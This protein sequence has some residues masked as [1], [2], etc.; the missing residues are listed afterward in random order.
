MEEKLGT[1]ALL[2][3][4]KNGTVDLIVALT[5]GLV[6]GMGHFFEIKTFAPQCL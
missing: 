5:E 2:N 3:L 1:G 4:L 6:A